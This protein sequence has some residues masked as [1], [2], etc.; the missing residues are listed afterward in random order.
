ML[1]TFIGYK[2]TRY[3]LG[4]FFLEKSVNKFLTSVSLFLVWSFI[5]L[6]IVIEFTLNS[7]TAVYQ[8]K[9]IQV[10]R[11]I[12]KNKRGDFLWNWFAL[13]SIKRPW[14]WYNFNI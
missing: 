6:R 7:S 10:S 4:H 9:R 14:I 11:R 8:N 13:S 2:Y 12:I 3:I 5:K 1:G